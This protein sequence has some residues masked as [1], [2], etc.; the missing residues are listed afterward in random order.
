MFDAGDEDENNRQHHDATSMNDDDTTELTIFFKQNNTRAAICQVHVPPF[1]CKFSQALIP[2]VHP[3]FH[4]HE[5][6]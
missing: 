3:A 4:M 1:L 2:I 5:T 6:T